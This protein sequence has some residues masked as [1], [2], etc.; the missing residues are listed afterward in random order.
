MFPL[1]LTSVKEG[2][3][4]FKVPVLLL[5]PF[6]KMID[7]NSDSRAY[8]Y[9]C[10]PEKRCGNSGRRFYSLSRC[11]LRIF[12][13]AVFRFFDRRLFFLFAFFGFFI[14]CPGY[15]RR[16]RLFRNCRGT[17]GFLFPG[18]GIVCPGSLFWYSFRRGSRFRTLCC[19]RSYGKSRN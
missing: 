18:S 3:Y 10:N 5:L 8:C 2:T 1:Y 6:F 13:C 14:A 16:F 12:P 11:F 7:E 15:F 4:H 9:G 17:L 19:I